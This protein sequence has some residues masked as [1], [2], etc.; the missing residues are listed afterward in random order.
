MTNLA[1]RSQEVDIQRRI[2]QMLW[3]ESPV[4][5]SIF[6][7]TLGAFICLCYVLSGKTQAQT[8]NLYMCNNIQTVDL[9][10]NETVFRLCLHEFQMWYSAHIPVYSL[11]RVVHH[12]RLCCQILC[13]LYNM[14]YTIVYYATLWHK[15]ENLNYGNKPKTSNGFIPPSP[16]HMHP[17]SGPPYI[18]GLILSI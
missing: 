16:H 5:F 7:L 18:L 3:N 15:Q 10:L 13:Y 4:G 14:Y 12:C 11:R 9:I 1:A 2:N 6:L 8:G 17:F